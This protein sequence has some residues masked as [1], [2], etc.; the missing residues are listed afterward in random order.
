M[1]LGLANITFDC[2]D[3]KKMSSFWSAVTDRPVDEGASD[4]FASIGMTTAERPRWLFSQVN[5]AKAAKNRCH[6][7]LESTD[8]QADIARLVELG[9]THVADK[10]E[11]NHKWSVMLDPE[12]N[13]FCISG[14]H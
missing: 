1:S 2:A 7:D 3:P 13:E 9:A 6:L 14:P 5:E 11:W 12:G 4:F 8:V 10:D